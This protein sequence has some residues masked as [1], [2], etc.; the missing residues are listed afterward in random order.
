MLEI[1]DVSNR[2]G[3]GFENLTGRKFD[4]LT[5]LGLSPKKIGR[6][7]YWVCKCICGNEILVR[8]DSL[9]AGDVRSCGC[10]K[11]EQDKIN[12]TSLNGKNI[13]H[14]D[15][16]PGNV[17]RI[18]REWSGIKKRTTNPKDKAFYRY[19]GRGIKMC[20]EWLN[21]YETFRDWAYEN[22]YNDNLTIERIDINKGYEPSNCKWIPFNEQANNRRR[23]IW[24]EWNVK[25]QNLKQWADEYGLAYSCVVER[26][27]K[28]KTPPELFKPSNAKKK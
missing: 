7:S 13:K 16:K 8:S 18:W 23:T 21:S 14:G 11:K 15:A 19:G 5:V 9:K 17:K 4:R 1:I 27:R 22:G 26:Y 20:D 6:K 3:N 25:Q 12:M 10:L 2:K 28:G 24:I